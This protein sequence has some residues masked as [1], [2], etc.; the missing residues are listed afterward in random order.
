MISHSIADW[1]V[2]RERRMKP[3]VFIV[4]WILMFI[5]SLTMCT[6]FLI[7]LNQRV[8]SEKV[9]TASSA[10][11]AC[12]FVY[13][14]M[15]RATGCIKCGSPL[16]WLRKEVDRKYVGNQEKVLEVGRSWSQGPANVVD[17]Y[18]RN[19]RVEKVRYRCRK[20]RTE[21]VEEHQIPTSSYRFRTS[22][23]LHDQS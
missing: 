11:L 18:A 19:C 9:V 17:I 22:I 6:I 5:L 10:V 3:L 7:I 21:W 23:N 1:F 13:L 14:R 4:E 16:P 8:S 12:A 2:E 20:C 15:F